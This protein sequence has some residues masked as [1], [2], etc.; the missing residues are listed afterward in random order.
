MRCNLLK[1]ENS[2]IISSKS[3]SVTVLF[4][5][6]VTCSL[7]F[8]SGK[9]QNLKSLKTFI[10]QAS[11]DWYIQRGP[12][13]HSLQ[14]SRKVPGVTPREQTSTGLSLPLTWYHCTSAV[15]SMIFATRFAINVLS[16]YGGVFNQAKVTELS[17]KANISLIWIS[18]DKIDFVYWMSLD[19]KWAAISS[20]RGI[21]TVF[22]GATLDFA[23][24]KLILT[25][26]SASALRI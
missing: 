3:F 21:E 4:W 24:S 22:K 15:A 8:S 12:C 16:L 6:K 10:G 7:H 9:L 25:E 19:N 5:I 18:L 14:I 1:F 26:P 17:V 20:R 2:L 23:N 13:S 11:L